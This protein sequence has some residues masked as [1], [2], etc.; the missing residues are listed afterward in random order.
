[1]GQH[2]QPR[3]DDALFGQAGLQITNDKISRAD[4]K[5]DTKWDTKCNCATAGWLENEV[6]DPD[7]M[8]GG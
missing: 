4:T 5:R 3:E 8:V 6:P 7:V 1:M 2:R